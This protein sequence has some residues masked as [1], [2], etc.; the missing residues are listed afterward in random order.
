MRSIFSKIV[1]VATLGLALVC[2]FSCS[3]DD[4]TGGGGQGGSF[5]ENSQVYNFDGRNIGT[6][7]KGSGDII[8][9][10][11]NKGE[12][13][14]NVG[15]VKNG[16]VNLKL[17]EIPEEY[18]REGSIPGVP[19]CQNTPKDV[20]YDIASLELYNNE[21]SIG[22]LFVAYLGNDYWYSMQFLYS[23]KPVKITC[24]YMDINTK[25]GWNNVYMLDG[26]LNGKKYHEYLVTNDIL[27]RAGE[28]KWVL[29]I[30]DDEKNDDH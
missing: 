24:D 14:I 22:R 7:Y 18:L 23:S 1:L 3:S 19:N 25:T 29:Y 21:T 4:D 20:K 11:G 17:P 13:L 27:K 15:S 26:T 16:V 5:N 30:D 9:T 2:T 8:L 6:A 12:I 28:L 10:E